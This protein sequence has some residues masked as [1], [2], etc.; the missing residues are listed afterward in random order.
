MEMPPVI[1]IAIFL[2]LASAGC[3][4][5][6]YAVAASRPKVRAFAQRVP[7]LCRASV[8]F[9]FEP[10]LIPRASRQSARKNHPRLLLHALFRFPTARFFSRFAQDYQSEG[11]LAPVKDP[12]PPPDCRS[13]APTVACPSGNYWL[14]AKPKANAFCFALPDWR[15]YPKGRTHMPFAPF[16]FHVEGPPVSFQTKNRSNLQAWKQMVSNA[17]AHAWNNRQPPTAESL[18]FTITYDAVATGDV[19]NIIKPIQDALNGLIYVDDS[20][21][22]DVSCRKRQSNLP[23]VFHQISDTLLDGLTLYDEFLHI[24]IEAAPNPLIIE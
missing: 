23:F 7:Q 10:L 11:L 19:D 12:R 1:P 20:Q 14:L 4:S 17:A 2:C 3:D 22:T 16:E 8:A 6:R 18:K 9:G 15:R 21:I 13:E 24:V 5:C